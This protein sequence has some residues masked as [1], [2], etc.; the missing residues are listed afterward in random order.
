MRSHR[1]AKFDLPVGLLALGME[2]HQA[3]D[4]DSGSQAEETTWKPCEK[5]PFR[6]TRMPPVPLDANQGVRYIG[7]FPHDFPWLLSMYDRD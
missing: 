2:S 4:G 5:P 1:G 7:W 3:R 6:A